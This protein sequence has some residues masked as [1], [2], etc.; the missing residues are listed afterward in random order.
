M[1]LP[2]PRAPIGNGGR[3]SIDVLGIDREMGF[4][5]PGGELRNL[6]RDWTCRLRPTN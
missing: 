5:L 1:A 6:E 3:E 2:I 4:L